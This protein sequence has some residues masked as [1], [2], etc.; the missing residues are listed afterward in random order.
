M[1]I[2]AQARD[3]VAVLCG[4]LKASAWSVE[5]GPLRLKMIAEA[6]EAMDFLMRTNSEFC[7]R[8]HY[9]TSPTSQ[10]RNER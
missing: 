2:E 8:E 9:P 1:S 5:P 3:R 10:V 6:E 7:Q 4:V